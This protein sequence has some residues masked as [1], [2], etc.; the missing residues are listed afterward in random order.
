MMFESLEELDKFDDDDEPTLEI[1]LQNS[2]DSIFKNMKTKIYWEIPKDKMKNDYDN[3]CKGYPMRDDPYL[4]ELIR[5]H[6][7]ELSDIKNVKFRIET[8][9]KKYKNYY[10][11][12]WD[13][14]NQDE[15][16]DINYSRYYYDLNENRKRLSK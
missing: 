13:K 1:Y 4:I 11:V 7:D 12:I 9:P 8:I 3:E 14:Q 6:G 10:H 15:V 16:I 2:E 5:K